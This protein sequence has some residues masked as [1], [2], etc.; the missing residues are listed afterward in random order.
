MSEIAAK[1]QPINEWERL[2]KQGKRRTVL[3][4]EL[5]RGPAIVGAQND[6]PLALQQRPQHCD[7]SW[8]MM[9]YEDQR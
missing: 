1:F 9:G 6:I 4:D 3:K 7:A 2:I 5:L 8:D